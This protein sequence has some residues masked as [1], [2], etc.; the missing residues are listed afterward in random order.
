[1]NDYYYVSKIYGSI[2]QRIY[3]VYS[4]NRR[5]LWLFLWSVDTEFEKCRTNPPLYC[6][7]PLEMPQDPENPIQTG[8]DYQSTAIKELHMR[9]VPIQITRS[10]AVCEI[11]HG[12]E[13]H[14]VVTSSTN[15]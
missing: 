6:Y 14:K 2:N 3:I 4:S 13:E 10:M 5:S 8:W 1:M 15:D 7:F 11:L 9:S 12:E